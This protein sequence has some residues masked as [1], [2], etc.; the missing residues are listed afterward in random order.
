M[1]LTHSEK[2]RPGTGKTVKP[3]PGEEFCRVYPS[4]IEKAQKK[5]RV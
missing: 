4:R 5:S 3:F 2:F 1:A